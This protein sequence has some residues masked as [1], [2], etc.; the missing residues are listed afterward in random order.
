MRAC[1]LCGTMTRD[2]SKHLERQHK[3]SKE[4]LSS[5]HCVMD[6]EDSPSTVRKKTHVAIGDPTIHNKDSLAHS[7]EMTNFTPG[8][9]AMDD[10]GSPAPPELTN[11]T[12]GDNP[13]DNEDSQTPSTEMTNFTSEYPAID[14]GDKRRGS[15]ALGGAVVESI[16]SN[17][18]S[19]ED[20][21]PQVS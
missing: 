5:K 12:P 17:E 16:P 15:T 3:L 9:P 19:A 2:M 6:N 11:S 14:D 18:L 10:K 4:T 21:D 1:E 20:S 8:N 7:A 13:S